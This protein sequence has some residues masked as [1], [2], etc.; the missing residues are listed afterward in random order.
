MSSSGVDNKHQKRDSWESLRSL[1]LVA[2]LR[3]PCRKRVLFEAA[4][5]SGRPRN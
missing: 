2:L 5:V 4:F 3:L 1:G